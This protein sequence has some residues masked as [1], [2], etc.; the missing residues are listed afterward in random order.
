MVKVWTPKLKLRFITKMNN[1]RIQGTSSSMDLLG[2][3]RGLHHQHHLQHHLKMIFQ[4]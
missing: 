2:W 1:V 4:I 3:G